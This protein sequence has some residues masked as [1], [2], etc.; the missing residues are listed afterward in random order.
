MFCEQCGS[1]IADGDKFCQECGWKVTEEVVETVAAEAEAAVEAVAEEA[2][3]AEAAVETV[4]EEAAEAVEAVTEEVKAVEETVAEE[5]K[6]AVENVITEAAVENI[7]E[8]AAPVTA[9]VTENPAPVENSFWSDTNAAPSA[10]ENVSQKKSRKKWPFVVLGVVALVAILVVAN[11][12]RLRNFY[13][14]MVSTP[15]EYYQIIETKQVD[16]LV[17]TYMSG[18]DEYMEMLDMESFGGSVNLTVELGEELIDLLDMSGVEIDWFES[19]NLGFDVTM[20]DELYKIGAIAGINDVDIISGNAIIDFEE[21]FMYMQTPELNEN[22]IGASFEDMG[23]EIDEEMFTTFEMFKKYFPE[24]EDLENLLSKYILLVVEQ[25]DDVEEESAEL[26]VG[27]ISQKCTALEV[28]IDTETAQKIAEAVLTEASKDKDLK[29]LFESVI[30]MAEEMGYPVDA[31]EI[32]DEFLVGVEEALDS[33]EYINMGENEIVMTVYVNGKGEVIGREIEVADVKFRYAMPQKGSKFE[34]EC[35]V[36]MPDIFRSVSYEESE[37]IKFGIEGEGKKKGDKIT[38]DFSVKVDSE[39]YVNIRVEG[40]NVEKAKEGAM[41]GTF[42]FTLPK[43]LKNTLSEQGG[44]EMAM[45]ASYLDYGLE[46]DMDTDSD[47]GTISIALVLNDEFLVKLTVESESGKGEKISVPS[48][49]DVV[50]AMDEDEVEEWVE[51]FDWEAI[52]KKLDKA[53]VDEEY[54]EMLEDAIDDM[55]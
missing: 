51:E 52:L 8:V 53:K 35:Y 1:Q 21:E 10:T 42:T 27:D 38:G 7:A 12:A 40:Y 46:I 54:I 16:E 23:I 45:V 24:S 31:E 55:Y 26:E 15:E 32:Y 36:E 33:I 37:M 41:V 29:K 43:S 47:G 9:A 17:A 44:Y 50:D 11:F 14:K 13:Q 48:S 2:A 25:L 49:K 30:G 5:T 20:K 4:A 18:Y 3:E 34:M 19:A 39:A 6:E 28:T 22:Y